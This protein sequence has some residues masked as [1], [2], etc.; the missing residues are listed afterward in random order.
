MSF[1]NP[2]FSQY[3]SEPQQTMRASAALPAAGA[4]D[5]TPTVIECMGW[6]HM[7]LLCAYTRG[8]ANG[9]VTFYLDFSYGLAATTYYRMT[10]YAPGAVAA[11][12]DTAS[13]LQRET[14]TYTSQAAD[15]EYFTYDLEI[16]SNVKNIRLSARESGVAGTPGTFAANVIFSY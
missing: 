3:Q 6:T 14:L 13:L 4:Y 16:P 8:A 15:I 5:A 9:A 10:C 1:L 2:G 12:A 11:G 7:T